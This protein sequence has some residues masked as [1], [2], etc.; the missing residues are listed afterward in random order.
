MNS[1]LVEEGN[2]LPVDISQWV[3]ME[4]HDILQCSPTLRLISWLL[5]LHYETCQISVVLLRHRSRY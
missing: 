3:L 5:G 4:T 2:C 1:I